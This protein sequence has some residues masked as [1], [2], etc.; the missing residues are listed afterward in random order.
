[1]TIPHPRPAGLVAEIS[2]HMSVDTA[3]GSTRIR[4]YAWTWLPGSAR[5]GRGRRVI[6]YT[7]S[8]G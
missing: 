7:N 1:M 4:P 2:A 3:A 8:K 5:P 6:D